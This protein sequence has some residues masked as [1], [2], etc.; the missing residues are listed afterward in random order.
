MEVPDTLKHKMELFKARGYVVR[1]RWEMFHLPSW[2]AIF[3]GFDYLPATYDRVVD[4]YDEQQLLEGFAKMR[5]SIK[6]ATADAYDH[7]DFIAKFCAV[8]K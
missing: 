5:E 7:E 3:T 2:L 6:N 4:T 1:Y 8:S